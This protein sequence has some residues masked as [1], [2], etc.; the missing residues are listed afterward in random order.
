MSG[1]GLRIKDLEFKAWSFVQ[2]LKV[3]DLGLRASFFGSGISRVGLR[4]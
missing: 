2:G 1:I 3:S 4:L